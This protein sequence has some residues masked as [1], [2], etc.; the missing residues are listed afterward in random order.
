MNGAKKR[1]SPAAVDRRYMFS[2]TAVAGWVLKISTPSFKL[3][4]IP[5]PSMH[6]KIPLAPGCHEPL[7]TSPQKWPRWVRS[8]LFAYWAARVGGKATPGG[9]ALL[10]FKLA[11]PWDELATLTPAL[12]RKLRG[13]RAFEVDPQ[14]TGFLTP[15]RTRGANPKIFFDGSTEHVPTTPEL[16]P[17]SNSAERRRF[18]S[19]K[20]LFSTFF[21]VPI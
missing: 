15:A 8:G 17:T 16:H 4:Q 21:Q 13:W 14:G 1:L 9:L 2:V 20:E 19:R 10:D 3:S 6:K 12:G 5:V 18:Y 11:R 7:A